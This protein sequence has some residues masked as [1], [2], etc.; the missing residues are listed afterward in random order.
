MISAPMLAA[1]ALLGAS[2]LG[3][4]SLLVAGTLGLVITSVACCA[5]A[6]LAVRAR[7]GVP[8][9][10]VPAAR[11]RSWP[12]EPFHGYRRIR[13]ALDWGLGRPNQMLPGVL[14]RVA[15]AVLAERHGVELDRDPDAA[16]RV[17]GE[18][19]WALLHAEGES[20]VER[21]DVERLTDRLERL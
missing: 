21:A 1:A 7:L 6:L 3:L 5:V 17:L 4:A 19:A 18:R 9:W 15:A 8:S 12:A 10:A 20:W 13:F 14:R 11:T 2:V 16:R